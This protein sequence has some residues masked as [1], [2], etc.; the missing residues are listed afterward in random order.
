MLG[1]DFP[2]FQD[3]LYTRIVTYVEKSG[4]PCATAEA[5]LSGNA[6]RLYGKG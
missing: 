3:E 5:I 2:Y 4:L 6:H 1:S